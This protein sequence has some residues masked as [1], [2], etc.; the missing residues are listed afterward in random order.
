MTATKTTT[1]SVVYATEIPAIYSVTTTATR[2]LDPVTVVTT[3]TAMSFLTPAAERQVD[4]F[5]DWVKSETCS[6]SSLDLYKPELP[7]CKTRSDL[8]AAMSGGGRVGFDAPYQTRGCGES[9]HPRFRYT[10]RLTLLPPDMEWYSTEK[11]CSI[12]HRFDNVWIVGDSMMRHVAHAVSIFLRADLVDGARITWGG[13]RVDDESET[14]DCRCAGS[15][16]RNCSYYYSVI[17]TGSVWDNDRA[18]IR[19]GDDTKPAR[20]RFMWFAAYP[21][22]EDSIEYFV[23]QLPDAPSPRDAFVLGHGGWNSFH[24]EDTNSWL[25]QLLD[26]LYDKRPAFADVAADADASMRDFPR[27]FVSPNAQG[28]RKA[29]LFS[30][31]Q[32]NIGLQQFVHEIDGDVRAR[33]FE[34]LA[35]YNMTVQTDSWDGTHASM[36]ANLVKAMMIFNWLDALSNKK[37]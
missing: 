15:F 5:S 19:C 11:I 10:L 12:L 3:T 33:G 7:M 14:H 28:F 2:T 18:S 30:G 16:L 20:V 29:R 23:E 17:D 9:S 25:D 35:T 32:N 6:M 34:H 31:E 4:H 37:T 1:T 26:T 24:R 27:L 8:L 22:E 36:Q 21:L 13:A